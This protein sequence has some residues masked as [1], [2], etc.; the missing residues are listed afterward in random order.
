VRRCAAGDAEAWRTLVDSY[1]ALIAG[2]SRRLLHRRMGRASEA[3][4]DEIA[5]EVFLSLLRR[6]RLLLRRFDPRYR[7]S[8]Y[9]GVLCRT[10]V[11]RWLRRRV[12]EPL[13]IDTTAAAQGGSVEPDPAAGLLEAER[14]AAVEALRAALEELSERDRLLLTLRY[15]DG[16]DYRAI[17]E[18]LGLN[19][20]SVG[21]FLTRAKARLAR[22]IPH[23]ERWLGLP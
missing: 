7:L 11:S 15:L 12:R 2:L 17:A 1:G 13:S 6:D 18:A 20:Q 5:A 4:V 3:D 22:R 16:L 10:E 8:T 9:L 19:E 21:Q 23:V 14:A